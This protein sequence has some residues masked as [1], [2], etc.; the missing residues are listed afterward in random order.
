MAHFL[1]TKQVAVKWGV[2]SRRVAVLCEQGRV[3]SAEKV[4]GVW[5]IPPEAKKPKDARVRGARN[6][7]RGASAPKP[8]GRERG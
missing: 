5:L 6:H 1:T 3:D 4:G 8:K 2:S 7:A